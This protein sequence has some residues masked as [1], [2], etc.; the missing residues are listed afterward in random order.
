VYF[1]AS[2]YLDPGGAENLGVRQCPRPDVFEPKVQRGPC[3][4]RQPMPMQKL[5]ILHCRPGAVLTITK[6][7]RGIVI[8][9]GPEPVVIP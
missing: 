4:Q 5:V 2:I 1:S 7:I 8:G 6:H 9:S 3:P